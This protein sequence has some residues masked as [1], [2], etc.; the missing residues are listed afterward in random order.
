MKI[1]N[2]KKLNAFIAVFM[3][4]FMA[5]SAFALSSQSALIFEGTVH[6]NTALELNITEF[7]PIGVSAIQPLGHVPWPDDEH[8]EA[9]VEIESPLMHWGILPGNRAAEFDIE[10]F[11]PNQYITFA[12]VIANVG[13]VAADIYDL[14]LFDYHAIQGVTYKLE[15]HEDEC[16]ASPSNVLLPGG[17]HPVITLN[18]GDEVWAR[19]TVAFLTDGPL[20]NTWQID[21][22]Y[23]PA[24]Y[25]LS[26]D[27]RAALS[28]WD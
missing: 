10:F 14:D 27:Y 2:K 19:V 4:V 6:A 21:T 24:T 11:Q 18:P 25:R 26:V 22:G 3:V 13:T 23:N 5:G 28:L 7:F 1:R 12:T 8:E 9:E 15:I 20:D 16:W 17:N